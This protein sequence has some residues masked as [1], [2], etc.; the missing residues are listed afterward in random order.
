MASIKQNPTGTFSAFIY[1]I[2]VRKCKTFPTREAAQKW[3][4][5][6]EKRVVDQKTISDAAASTVLATMIP[7]RMLEA[8][9]S[10]P[11]HLDEIL[12]S[13]IPSHSFT[14]IYFLVLNREI[15]YIGQSVDVL[16]RISR[17]RREG[18]EFDSYTYLLC[19]KSRLDELEEKYIV[20]LMPW[21]NKTM[22]GAI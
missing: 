3:A 12:N 10:I 6:F 17:H 1:K 4:S 11:F 2:G 19:D 16:Y 5:N 14:G 21:M 9:A 18:K 8:L 13:T 22:G 20:A 7:K 15:V